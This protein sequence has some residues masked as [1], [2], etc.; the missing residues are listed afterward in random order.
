MV[1]HTTFYMGLWAGGT[2]VLIWQLF[3]A[4]PSVK[5]FKCGPQPLRA[6][7]ETP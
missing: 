6:R 7:D 4:V 3:Y 5:Y 1:K 2:L